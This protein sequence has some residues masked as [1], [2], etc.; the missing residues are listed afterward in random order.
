MSKAVDSSY[1][2]EGS[3]PPLFM[4]HGIGAR[5]TSWAALTQHLKNDFTCI[6]RIRAIASQISVRWMPFSANDNCVSI[7]PYGMPVS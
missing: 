2:V 5:K 1:V 4:I 7:N 3:G 6:A